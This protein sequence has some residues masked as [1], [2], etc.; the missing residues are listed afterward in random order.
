MTVGTPM[1]MTRQPS[2]AAL[3]SR[4]RFPIPAPGAIPVSLICTVVLTLRISFAASASMTSTTSGLTIETTFSIRSAVSIPVTPVTEGLNPLTFA[5]SQSPSQSNMANKWRV[6]FTLST[7][8]GPRLSGVTFS[9]PS[10]TTSTLR[11]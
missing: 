4:R 8:C 6:I 10:P 9:L 7:V 5:I 3:I 2:V 1:E 11:K